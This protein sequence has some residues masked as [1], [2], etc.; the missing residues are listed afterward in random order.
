MAIYG[1][2]W[3]FAMTI[4]VVSLENFI[5]N[6]SVLNTLPNSCQEFIATKESDE[7]NSSNLKRQGQINLQKYGLNRAGP[8]FVR[9]CISFQCHTNDYVLT[10]CKTSVGNDDSQAKAQKQRTNVYFRSCSSDE[11]A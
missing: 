1:L 9:K 5:G 11:R 10:V 3:C 6:V 4:R 7:P 8:L 2:N